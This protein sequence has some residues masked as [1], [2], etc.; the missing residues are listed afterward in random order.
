MRLRLTRPLCPI[1]HVT[2]GGFVGTDS[3][4]LRGDSAPVRRLVHRDGHGNSILRILAVVQI[5]AIRGVIKVNIIVVVPIIRPILRPRIDDT[6]PVSAVLE[7]R[8][9][10]SHRHMIPTQA[11]RM[12]RPKVFAITEVRNPVTDVPAALPPVAM[13]RP[14][15]VC[16][17]FI[18]DVR[19]LDVPSA[20]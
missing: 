16:A 11:E 12:I 6:D 1:R 2:D 18:P 17:M 13:L 7:A 9:S 8:M 15:I 10:A 3:L 20:V 5:I 14:P 19:E 4:R